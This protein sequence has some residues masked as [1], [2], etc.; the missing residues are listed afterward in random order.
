MVVRNYVVMNIHEQ[1]FVRTY[2]YFFPQGDILKA[3]SIFLFYSYH[4]TLLC[5]LG[6]NNVIAKSLGLMML[7]ILH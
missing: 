5:S 4:S 7:R 6:K 2:I 1:G 3:A